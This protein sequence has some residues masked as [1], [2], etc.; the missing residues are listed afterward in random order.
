MND[1]IQEEKLIPY[2]CSNCEEIVFLLWNRE[3]FKKTYRCIT[4]KKVKLLR[5]NEVFFGIIKMKD[6]KEIGNHVD[7]LFRGLI[8]FISKD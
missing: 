8:G 6:L 5:M 1:I 4:C 3:T 7:K 2:F